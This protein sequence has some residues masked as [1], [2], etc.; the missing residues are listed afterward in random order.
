VVANSR[1]EE[2]QPPVFQ[3]PAAKG[4]TSG[5]A[6]AVHS[7][8]VLLTN[9][10]V[11]QSCSEAS[12]IDRNGQAQVGRIGARDARNDLA[13]ITLNS[14]IKSIAS[15][16]SSPIR[17][18]EDVIALGFPLS[19]LLAADLNVS[20]GIVS[21]T[22]GLLNDTSLLQISAGVQPGNSGGPMLDS[23]GS[24]AGVVVSKLDAIMVA[25]LTGDI[26][27]NINF[28]IKSEV[29][30]VF[31][32]SQRL[33]PR[34]ASGAPGTIAVADAVEAAR[35]YTFLVQ[36]DP[37]RLTEREKANAERGAAQTQEEE[38]IKEEQRAAVARS[39]GDQK[40]REE[41]LVANFRLSSPI[42]C[43]VGKDCGVLSYFSHGGATA[44]RDYA[45]GNRAVP[46]NTATVFV[47]T[48]ELRGRGDVGVLAAADG[49][50][51]EVGSNGTLTIR[52]VGAFKTRYRIQPG[53]ERVHVGQAVRGGDAIGL[54]GK[55]GKEAFL[56]LPF[57]VLKDDVAV[58]PFR[59][60]SQAP[61]D[62]GR[63]GSMWEAEAEGRLRYEATEVLA[64]GFTSEQVD[65]GKVLRG[66]YRDPA[67][68]KERWIG[69]YAWIVGVKQD[70][71]VDVS[72]S[73]PDGKVL[74]S[75]MEHPQKGAIDGIFWVGK[76]RAV[77]TS[78]PLGRYTG[79]FRVTR[80]GTPILD[81]TKEIEWTKSPPGSGS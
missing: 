53:S 8:G 29:V 49:T 27:Q 25:S 20:K 71:Q 72:I 56:Q 60:L 69:V 54:V 3:P 77:L 24:V 32:R 46:G 23:A 55:L 5:T 2:R 76:R 22:A 44:S 42:A 57:A 58:D 15:F 10:H 33:E 7:S 64:A 6:F 26:P 38:R 80:S 21:A 35:G 67:S 9:N 14:P 65:V 4:P 31:L 61:Q 18:G 59:S 45:C 75:R 68:P 62:C 52:H 51:D 37:A 1:Q 47:L 43:V 78:W 50:V 28:A 11:V 48:G 36:C 73:G 39:E 30:A 17:A 19:G 41:A 79:H 81:F 16:R 13:L 34:L 70:D 66:E 40:R 63:G 12:V 74:Y